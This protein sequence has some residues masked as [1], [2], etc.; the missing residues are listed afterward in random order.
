M[1]F[2][3]RITNSPRKISSRPSRRLRFIGKDKLRLARMLPEPIEEIAFSDSDFKDQKRE[4]VSAAKKLR[5]LFEKLSRPLV[6][7]WKKAKKLIRRI[8]DRLEARRQRKRISSLPMLAGALCASVLVITVT[9]AYVL[10]ALVAPYVRSYDT[11]T[12]PSFVGKTADGAEYDTDVFNLIIQYENNPSVADGTV[13]SQFP[14]AGVTRK[15]YEKDG[16]CDVRLTVS[17]HT[18]P[19]TPRGLVG[20]SLR[21]AALLVKNSGFTYSVEKIYSSVGA[22]K[23]ISTFPAENTSLEYGDEIKLTVSMGER[24]KMST[25]PSLIGLTEAEAAAR[26]RAA[27]LSLGEVSYARSSATAGTVISQSHTAH[28]ELA[29][30]SSVS[31]T[32]SAG[33]SYYVRA[34]PDLYGLTLDQAR[35]RL[36][37]VGLTLGNT[38]PISSQAPRGTV[39]SQFPLPQTPLTSAIFSV[40]VHVSS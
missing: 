19:K 31:C 32:I 12:I 2:R 25:V 20:L 23:V 21:D 34:V 14:A 18:Q 9:A 1:K 37:E 6:L 17:K 28:S 8:S 38:Y 7:I 35:E 13:I 10:L 4:K 5:T 33:E 36:R 39:I 22:G 40:D 27:G 24:A 30:N 26:L 11:V 16:Y 29:P 3:F 15:I